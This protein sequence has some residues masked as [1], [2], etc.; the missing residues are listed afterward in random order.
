MEGEEML[1]V[2][3]VGLFTLV[4]VGSATAQT[5]CPQGGN[6]RLLPQG[7]VRNKGRAVGVLR[8]ELQREKLRRQQIAI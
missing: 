2:L 3:I 8:K 7:P 4:L 5:T 6:S 1:K